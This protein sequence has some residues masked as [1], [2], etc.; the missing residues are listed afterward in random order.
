[1]LGKRCHVGRAMEGTGLLRPQNSLV[2]GL[3]GNGNATLG[4]LTWQPELHRQ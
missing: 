3:T 4:P 2:M 1:M